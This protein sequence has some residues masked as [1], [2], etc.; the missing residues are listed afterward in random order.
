MVLKLTILTIFFIGLKAGIALSM[1][2]QVSTN[3]KNELANPKV[4]A[5]FIEERGNIQNLV[6]DS[7]FRIGFTKV[8]LRN[9]L[10]D[11][12]T[13][14]SSRKFSFRRRLEAVFL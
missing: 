3:N 1:D 11:F 6:R 2:G 10:F 7:N 13:I 4:A 8:N 9:L 14:Y 5:S 12:S